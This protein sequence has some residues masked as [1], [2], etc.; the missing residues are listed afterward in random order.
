[1]DD[2]NK[3]L[4][5]ANILLD[6]NGC[7]WDKKQTFE[8]LKKYFVEEVYELV[9]AIDE[10]NNYNIL[11]ELGDI[12]YLIIFLSKLAQ[13]QD[14][15]T[16]KEVINCISDKLI[17]RHPH[18]FANKE[19]NT[20]DD[21][22]RNWEEIKNKEKDKANRKNIF[23]GLPKSLPTLIK[24]QKIIKTLKGNNLIQNKEKFLTQK[25]LENEL[26]ELMIKAVNSDLDIE[27]ALKNKLKILLSQ[28][29]IKKAGDFLEA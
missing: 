13:I 22:V 8:T 24:A 6:E 5:I 12:L 29:N 14:K 28:K 27:E 9:D 20:I 25:D 16:I 10:K 23:D 1:M 21:I 4:D 15:F 18:V 7:E 3:L 17:R 2:F 11:E 26:F 19:I